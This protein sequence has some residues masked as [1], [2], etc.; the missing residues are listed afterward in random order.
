MEYPPAALIPITP[1]SP[2]FRHKSMTAK[3]RSAP[4]RLI[5]KPEKPAKS[6]EAKRTRTSERP[7]A[8][9]I[10]V[11]A[12]EQHHAYIGAS[13]LTPGR[14]IMALKIPSIKKRQRQREQYA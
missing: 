12:D 14:G 10:A 11:K 4:V 9:F 8:L 1:S 6:K 5:A 2:D 7:S 3:E 13:S